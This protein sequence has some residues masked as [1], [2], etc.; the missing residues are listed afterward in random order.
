VKGAEE[1]SSSWKIRGQ[2]NVFKGERAGYLNAD[3]IVQ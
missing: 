2:D 1:Q 3:G